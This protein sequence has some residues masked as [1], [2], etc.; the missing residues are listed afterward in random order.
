M[1]K[2]I[3]EPCYRRH[4]YGHLGFNK[5]YKH[6]ALNDAMTHFSAWRICKCPNV[7]KYSSDEKLLPLYPAD[8]DAGH[9]TGEDGHECGLFN[10]G[11]IEAQAKY[12]GLKASV[13]DASHKRGLSGAM[14]KLSTKDS[15]FLKPSSSSDRRKRVSAVFSGLRGSSTEAIASDNVVTDPTADKNVPQFFKKF[16]DVDAFSHTHMSLRVGPLVIENGV[17]R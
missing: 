8:Y 13:S 11:S 17:G 3:C 5:F 6:C 15:R 4:Y 2:V 9:L 7:P 1:G 16:E 10:L 12:E 14:S